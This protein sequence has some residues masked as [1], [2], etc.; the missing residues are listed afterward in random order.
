MQLLLGDSLTIL[1]TLPD[2]CVQTCVTS[3]PYWGGLR[4]YGVDG[5]LGLEETPEE[6]IEKLVL[7]FR[8]VRRVLRDDGT[9]W[10]NYGDCYYSTDLR[11]GLDRKRRI[12][13]LHSILKPK[14]LVGMSWR[15]AFALQADGWYLRQDCVWHK[16]NP[17]PESA[18]DRC[19]KAHEYIFLLSKS[20]RY[21]FDADAIKEPLVSDP[22]KIRAKI[23]A[24]QR[25][26]RHETIRD[27]RVKTMEALV[28]NTKAYAPTARNKRSVWTVSPKPYVGAHFATYPPELIR[29]CILAGA[30]TQHTVLDP[31]M[32]S[33]TTGYVARLL[34]RNFIGIELSPEY[35]KLA[36]KRI[37]LSGTVGTNS[38]STAVKASHREKAA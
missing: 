5:Q 21:H 26:K 37:G 38:F 13:T 3:P 36:K 34:Q 9:L 32:G 22:E 25:R 10:L 19:T 33:G 30:P 2:Q 28:S 6:H 12:G 20:E 29:P 31:F 14:D 1:K 35:M 27:K 17:M 8:E 18:R 24:A 23:E 15:V 16:P 4:D 7:V 11:R